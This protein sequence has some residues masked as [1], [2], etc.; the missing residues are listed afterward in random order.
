MS[1]AGFDI[2]ITMNEA[3]MMFTQEYLFNPIFLKKLLT[4][5]TDT[6]QKQYK[7]FTTPH[8]KKYLKYFFQEIVIGNIY[9][10]FYFNYLGP[11]FVNISGNDVFWGYTDLHLESLVSFIDKYS[12][13]L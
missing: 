1:I 5:N 12:L 13:L 6:F 8:F 9:I 7:S 2:D 3:K 11:M 10:N 4:D